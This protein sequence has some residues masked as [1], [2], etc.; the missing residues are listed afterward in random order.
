M[1]VN[2]KNSAPAELPS[3]S[4]LYVSR[5]LVLSIKLPAFVVKLAQARLIHGTQKYSLTAAFFRTWRVLWFS[6]A[7]DPALITF[8]AILTWQLN[9]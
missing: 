1:S 3:F 4:N 7:W 9:A 2:V 8:L 6:D 5:A